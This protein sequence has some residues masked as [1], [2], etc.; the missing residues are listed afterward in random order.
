MRL[1]I[2][3]DDGVVGVDGVFRPVDLSALPD[4]VRAVQWDSA[5]GSGHIE[6]DEGPNSE[7]TDNADFQY[8]IDLWTAAEPPAPP[9]PTPAEIKAAA[10][11]RIIAAYVAEINALI[12]GY[13]ETEIAS[14]PKQESEARAFLA[15]KDAATPW[16]KGS[17]KGRGIS[18]SKLAALIIQSADELAP[19]HGALTGKRQRLRDQI[20]ALGDSATQQQA[21]AIQW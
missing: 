18:V 1:T 14:W 16:L 20:D 13:P 10:H 8:F 19:L 5:T 15:N 9:D 2:I 21:D 17:A 6:Y 11:G 7:I 3:S 12:A 4:G